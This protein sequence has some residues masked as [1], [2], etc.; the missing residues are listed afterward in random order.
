MNETII[1]IDAKWHA[2]RVAKIK[3]WIQFAKKQIEWYQE[4]I[5][6]HQKRLEEMHEWL[7]DALT[8]QEAFEERQV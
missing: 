6:L 8:D 4:G 1:T 5:T 3:S 7:A 2:E